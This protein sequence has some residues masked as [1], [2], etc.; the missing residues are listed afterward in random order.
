MS[1]GGDGGDYARGR[2]HSSRQYV[3]EENDG[4]GGYRGGCRD[5]PGLSREVSICF[6][7]FIKVMKYDRYSTA[8]MNNLCVL[9]CQRSDVA[10]FLSLFRVTT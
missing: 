8:R 10:L 5:R 1:A 7:G 3:R 2:G 9:L 4:R 6:V